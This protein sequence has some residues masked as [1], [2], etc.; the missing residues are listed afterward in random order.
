[1]QAW[2]T[3]GQAGPSLDQQLEEVQA[4]LTPRFDEFEELQALL[5]NDTFFHLH[6]FVGRLSA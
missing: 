2:N 1:M 5:S 4:L 6:V 3:A